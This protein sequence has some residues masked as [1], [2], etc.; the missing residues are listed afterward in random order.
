MQFHEIVALKLTGLSAA[1]CAGP[2]SAGKSSSAS[3]RASSKQ[4]LQRIHS[5]AMHGP[6]QV[7]IVQDESIPL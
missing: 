6:Y 5:G 7:G 2:F 4:L 3:N 1:A